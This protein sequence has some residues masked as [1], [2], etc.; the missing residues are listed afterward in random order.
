MLPSRLAF[1]LC[2]TLCALHLGCS[3]D[4]GAGAT[5]TT[6]SG[7]ADAAVADSASDSGAADSSG[8]DSAGGG[9]DVSTQ[10][11]DTQDAGGGDAGQGD[12]AAT[13]PTWA[14]V[15]STIVK[16]VCANGYCHGGG[17]GSLKLSGDAAADYTAL[18]TGKAGSKDAAQCAAG[19]YVVPGK[20]AE[21]LLWLKVDKQASHGCGKKMPS[22]TDGLDPAQSALIKGWIAAGAKQ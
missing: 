14:T 19:S 12:A 15:H 16:P 21:S 8:A 20:P 2:L 17:S 6:D 1:P 5:T 3:G 9:A 10:D 4:D 13:A 7:P 22:S 18:T 11:A